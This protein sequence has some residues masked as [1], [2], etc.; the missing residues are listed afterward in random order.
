MPES[1]LRPRSG[2]SA[3]ALL[4]TILGEY[5]LPAGGSVWTRTVV[6]ALARFDVGEKNARQAVAR[7]AEQD[8][9]VSERIGREARWHLTPTGRRL[10]EDGTDRIYG[11]G[12]DDGG[13]DGRWL[14]VL[15]AV[16]EEQRAQRQQLRGRLGFAGFGFLSPGVAV[17]PHL[18]REQVATG[19]VEELGLE[20]SAVVLRAEVGELV[21]AEEFLVRAW[22]LDGLAA[23]YRSFLAD[24]ERR[25]P[26]HPDECFVALTELVHAWRRFPF[27]D[28]ELPAAV[29]PDDWPGGPAKACFDDRHA[30][31]SP[32]AQEWFAMTEK[33]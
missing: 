1:T 18:E 24:V 4:L 32:G 20:P 31:W 3:K 21:S 16:S 26:G 12:G 23:D 2:S 19:I 8:L 9:V 10:L 22:D 30:A 28:P 27:V 17:S 33:A 15:C 25:R 11:F 29:L 7:L 14:V 6:A 13:W 5:V